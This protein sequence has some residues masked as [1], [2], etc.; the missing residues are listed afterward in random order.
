MTGGLLEGAIFIGGTAAIL[1]ISRA[2]LRRTGSHG[3][4]RFFAWELLLLLFLLNMRKW[5]QE[6]F[7]PHQLVAWSLLIISV[8]LIVESVVW[9]RTEGVPSDT[10]VDDSLISIEKTTRLVT[11]G[12]YH[13]IR[14]PMYSSLLFLGWGIFFKN[15]SWLGSILAIA[16]SVF[17]V[18]TARFE[19]SEN[20]RFFGSDYRAYMRRTR[21][22][23][24]FLF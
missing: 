21:M 4:Y 7:A 6:P 3:F 1:Y 8:F 14:H 9:L 13:Y 10:R 19:E 17:L 20:I 22:F 24:P 12:I 15:P 2:S 23:V 16:A 5:F 11:E 18:L